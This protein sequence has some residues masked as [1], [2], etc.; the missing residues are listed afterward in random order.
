LA[1]RF[2]DIPGIEIRDLERIEHG[3]VLAVPLDILRGLRDGLV[4]AFH[5]RQG[6]NHGFAQ[7]GNIRLTKREFIGERK[8]GRPVAFLKKKRQTAIPWRRDRPAA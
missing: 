5:V 1:D 6:R 4:V 2:I 7:P 3:Q 8:R